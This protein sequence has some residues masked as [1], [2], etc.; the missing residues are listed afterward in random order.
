MLK[1]KKMGL[2]KGKEKNSEFEE[3]VKET[4]EKYDLAIKGE[5]IVVACSGGKDS[6]TVLYLMKKLG[7]EV[8]G[9][10]IDLG[11]GEW[12]RKNQENLKI[13]CEKNSIKLHT[14]EVKDFLGEDIG[15]L[16]S[17]FSGSSC[18]ACGIIKRWLLNK[19][20]RELGADK[21]ATGHNLDDQ[22]ETMLMNFLKHDFKL[23]L[24]QQPK[25]GLV[26]DRK[27]VPRIKPLFFCL[28]K[29]VMEY[30]KQ[31]SFPV[32]Y[33]KC[34]FSAGVFRRE[35]REELDTLERPYPEFKEQMVRN[36]LEMVKKLKRD[37][38]PVKYCE[39]CG[40]V[41]RGDVCKFCGLMESLEKFK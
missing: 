13:F 5:K 14:V 28:N 26:A 20:A 3:K 41:S 6:T 11:I 8:E 15:G 12:S 39:K 21:L 1:N 36:F 30:S 38:S 9:L 17:K 22:A 25:T 2:G 16:K 23:N 7:F 24:G 18:T 4:I 33:E 29:E 27:F 40:G 31:M 35:I 32:L 34:P 19:K 10:F 37:E